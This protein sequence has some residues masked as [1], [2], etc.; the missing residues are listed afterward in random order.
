[1]PAKWRWLTLPKARS[2]VFRYTFST[3]SLS[4]PLVN[5]TDCSCSLKI[6][7]TSGGR[8]LLA[9][10]GPSK[11]SGDR[12]LEV[13]RASFDVAVPI[14]PTSPSPSRSRRVALFKALMVLSRRLTGSTSNCA[15][16]CMGSL[17]TTDEVSTHMGQRYT[18][19]APTS[20]GAAYAT[21]GLIS[22]ALERSKVGQPRDSYSDG[23]DSAKATGT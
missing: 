21:A 16:L 6:S 7:G 14:T 1:M 20:S 22:S 2:A 11:T 3:S 5:C 12:N 19:C 17:T 15:A 9:N 4:A 23:P 13:W 10:T 18:P 8:L